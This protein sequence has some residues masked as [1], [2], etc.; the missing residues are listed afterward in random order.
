MKQALKIALIG[1]AHP[2]RGGIADFN[3]ALAL[4]LMNAGH[5]VR[6]F[7]FKFQYPSFLF[8]GKS[9]FTEAPAPENLDIR[10][11]IN[12]ISPLSW[13]STASS[14]IDFRPDFVV[15]RYWLPFMAPALGTICRRL[16]KNTIPVIAITDNI[17]PHESRPG[18]KSFTKYFVGSCDGFVA[19]SRSVLDDLS[20]FTVNR[21]KIFQPHPVYDIFG[22]PLSKS[23]ARSYLSLDMKSPVLLFFGFIRQYKG[24]MNLL[25]AMTDERL[26]QMGVKLIVAGEFY[27]D[28]KPYKDFVLS[29]G[30]Q[31][32][33]RFDASF[34]P[35]AEVNRYFC[36]AD[37]VVQPYTSATQSGITQIAYHFGR[38]MLVT[39]VGGLSEIVENGKT[40][41]VVP[42]SSDA[43]SD[44]IFDYFSNDRGEKMSEEVKLAAT[45][46]SWDTFINALV[47]LYEKVGYQG[48]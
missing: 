27:E 32:S 36:A 7:S 13:Y 30:L 41:Y 37:L 42:V 10:S 3:E 31:D 12:S 40:G 20:R 45:R 44:A 34:I 48:N 26:R 8:P 17:F 14:I 39:D 47:S 35:K 38:P 46:F 25:Q 6:I 28:E 18:D 2:L 1:P 15:V 5:T 11:T 29:N 23:T 4:G 9:Q 22:D 16:R 21:N 24:L 43:I 33:V 19:M